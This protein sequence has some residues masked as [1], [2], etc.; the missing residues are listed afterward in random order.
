LDDE[1]ALEQAVNDLMQANALGWGAYVGIAPRRAD[2]GRWRRGRK[3][4]LTCLPAL[5][6]DVDEADMALKKLATFPLPPSCIVQSSQHKF[7]FYW[8]LD[9]PTCYLNL[10][11][12]ILRGLADYFGGDKVIT[13]AQ[14]M[15]LPGSINNKLGRQITSCRLISMQSDLR[16]D[17]ADFSAYKATLRRSPIP[18]WS[19]PNS[20]NKLSM[21]T[22]QFLAKAVE[23]QLFTEYGGFIRKN[24]WLAALCPFPH[25]HDKPGMHFG[26]NPSFRCGY[27]FGRHGKIALD[28]LCHQLGIALTT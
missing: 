20:G 3:C 12:S 4:D 23:E 2:L 15:R 7:H 16:Y 14:S 26:F 8:F 5:F 18:H 22:A 9:K 28:E 27:C 11:D 1:A 25:T 17:L 6:I 13:V 19:R 21:G 10:A 24:G